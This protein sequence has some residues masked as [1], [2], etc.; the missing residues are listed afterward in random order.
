MWRTVQEQFAPYVHTLGERSLDPQ[1]ESG[2]VFAPLELAAV[3]YSEWKSTNESK[4]KTLRVVNKFI[5]N[6]EHAGTSIIAQRMPVHLAIQ[7]ELKW[8]REPKEPARGD[9]APLLNEF[10]SALVRSW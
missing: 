7:T 4:K 9:R 3:D 1:Q 6:G 2:E 10:T 8:L 5:V